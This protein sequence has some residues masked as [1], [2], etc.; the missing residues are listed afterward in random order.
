MS[1]DVSIGD[2]WFN[3]TWNVSPLFYD[4]I[5]APD[6]ETR[7][8]INRLDGLTGRQAAGVIS[9]A[10]ERIHSTLCR[11]DSVRSFRSK[12]DAENGWGSTDGALVFLAL[13]MAA[14]HANPRKRVRVS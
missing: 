12:Y 13:I 1:Y 3:Y 14:C 4:H 11:G 5:P 6:Q 7:G 8:G 2:E 10:F 9:E